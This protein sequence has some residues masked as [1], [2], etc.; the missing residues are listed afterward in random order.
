MVDRFGNVTPVGLA[1]ARRNGIAAGL[2]LGSPRPNPAVHGS[3]VTF[4]LD[5][6]VPVRVSISNVAGRTLR[7]LQEGTL[8]SGEH[9]VTWDGRTGEL[10]R[11]RPGVYY[12]MLRTPDGFKTQSIV[13]TR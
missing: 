6:S 11:A 9:T 10:E 1:S 7:V 2:A 5:R 8:P 4:R 13:V 3:S 12:F